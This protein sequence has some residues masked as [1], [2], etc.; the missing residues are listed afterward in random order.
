MMEPDPARA[1]GGRLP[2]A[3]LAVFAV[4]ATCSILQF[5][6]PALLSSLRRD[7]AALAA[8]QWWRV[9]TPLAVQDGGVAGT[10]FN[11]LFLAVLGTLAERLLGSR[12]WLLLYGLGGL[13][14]E[15]V[16]YAWDPN[17]A[18]NSVALCGLAGAVLAMALLRPGRVP[19]PTL[20]VAA[21]FAGAVTQFWP[22]TVAVAVVAFPASRARPRLAGRIAG[23]LGVL[24]AATLLALRDVHGAA[25]AAGLAAG[26][27]LAK[28][29]GG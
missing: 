4:T 25:L 19:A 18:G 1:P 22:L 10:I 7:P 29:E 5:P 11:L 28:L 2:V 27:V 3:T 26:A 16:G 24:V 21:I 9:V 17:G 15:A 12:R 20:A 23:V 14:G 8:G 13:V 6:F